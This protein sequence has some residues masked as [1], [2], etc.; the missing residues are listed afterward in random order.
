MARVMH[1]AVDAVTDMSA[2]D[3][4]GVAALASHVRNRVSGGAASLGDIMSSRPNGIGK[5]GR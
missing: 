5:G 4:Y 2:G 1:H 3:R